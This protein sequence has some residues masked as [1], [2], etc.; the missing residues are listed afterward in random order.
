[1]VGPR[2]APFIKDFLVKVTIPEVIIQ[3]VYLLGG[4]N[5]TE[6]S[7][8]FLS[9]LMIQLAGATSMSVKE[10]KG[11]HS[12]LKAELKTF[13]RDSEPLEYIVE[14]PATPNLMMKEHPKQYAAAYPNGDVPIKVPASLRADVMI[15]DIT[16]SC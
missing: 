13:V 1:M 12:Y 5:L 15:F 4:I 2:L 8:K 6:Y 11:W 10:R 16:Y 14:L 7:T 9:S 3:R